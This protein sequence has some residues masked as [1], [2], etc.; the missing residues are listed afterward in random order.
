MTE[1]GLGAAGPAAARIAAMPGMPRPI[2][3]ID[4]ACSSWR[5]VETCDR[6][7]TWDVEEGVIE[8]FSLEGHSQYPIFDEREMV[9]L[10]PGHRPGEDFDWFANGVGV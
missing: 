1:R 3:P 7:G 9:F 4:P 2:K 10:L 6:F 5:L 8:R